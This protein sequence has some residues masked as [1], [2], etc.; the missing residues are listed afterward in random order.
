MLAMPRK[1]ECQDNRV[2]EN[3]GVRQAGGHAAHL[4]YPNLPPPAQSEHVCVTPEEARDGRAEYVFAR[5][6][7]TLGF[8]CACGLGDAGWLVVVCGVMASVVGVEGV[9]QCGPRRRA[10]WF[11]VWSAE[12]AP[13][14]DGEPSTRLQDTEPRA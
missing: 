6:G 14:N 12:D 10:V 11:G 7:W 2:S 8:S 9:P 3:E 4:A 13:S 5:C 1:S